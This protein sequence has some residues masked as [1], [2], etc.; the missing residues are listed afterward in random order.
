MNKKTI[1]FTFFMAVLLLS[2]C[3]Q[4]NVNDS[5]TP[6]APADTSQA[7]DASHTTNTSQTT[8]T[9]Q[10]T[11]TSQTTDASLSTDN[12]QSTATNTTQNNGEE[13][14]TISE[15]EA[16]QIALT[17]AGLTAEQVT[18]IKSGIDTENGRKVY[19]VEFY[20]NDHK[21]YDYEIDPHTG[22]VLDYDYD[23][24]SHTQS[25]DTHN[26]KSISEEEA[27][28]IA[29]A[30]VPGATAQDIQHF[31]KD[32]KNGHLQYEGKIYYDK[33]EYEFEIDGY[34]GAIIEWDVE[35]L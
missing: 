1:F 17:H 34:N 26:G 19:D 11:N 27:K 33:K 7:A 28:Q 16:K 3:G 9:S 21:E 24:E 12:Q 30:Q 6:S 32:S 35:S 4:K 20:T 15:E 29:L 8:D 22:E 14:V 10:A 2:G 25:A 23:A 5:V 18:F 13:T 31:K